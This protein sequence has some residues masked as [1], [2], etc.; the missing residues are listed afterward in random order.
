[1]HNAHAVVN[2]VAIGSTTNLP[3]A[4]RRYA[5]V[6]QY[7][8]A[9]IVVLD[10]EAGSVAPTAAA[11]LTAAPG[12]SQISFAVSLCGTGRHLYASERLLKRLSSRPSSCSNMLIS[13]PRLQWN[14]KMFIVIQV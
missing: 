11:T 3:W 2:A 4:R 10:L 7:F 6:A 13:Y 9:D 12:G 14:K 5:Y 8:S 1:M